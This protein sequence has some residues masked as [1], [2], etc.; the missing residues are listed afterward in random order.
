MKA[1]LLFNNIIFITGYLCYLNNSL[2]MFLMNSQRRYNFYFI[3]DVSDFLRKFFQYTRLESFIIPF[4]ES[5]F[6]LFNS[7]PCPLS[8]ATFHTYFIL[9]FI[10]YLCQSF[11]CYDRTKRKDETIYWTL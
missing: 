6:S 4:A 9:Y 3:R 10:L 2:E 7:F 8:P 5:C 11:I 1:Y